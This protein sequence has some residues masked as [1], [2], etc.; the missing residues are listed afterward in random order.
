MFLPAV[1]INVFAHLKKIASHASKD[2]TGP[3]LVL[4]CAES[5]LPVLSVYV[6]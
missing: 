2:A 1:K 3:V 4:D 5:G 6:R